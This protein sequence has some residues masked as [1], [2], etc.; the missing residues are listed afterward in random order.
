M[1]LALA[2]LATCGGCGKRAPSKGEAAAAGAAGLTEVDDGMSDGDAASLRATLLWS[3]AKDGELEDLATLAVHE[4][5]L[6]LMEAVR[7]PTLRRTAIEAMGYARGWAQLPFLVKVGSGKNDEEAKLALAAVVELAT[8][9]LRSEDPE[10]ASELRE[11]CVA[12]LALAR[13][14]AQSRPRRVMAV[15]ALRMMPCPSF[16]AGSDD[17]DGIPTDVDAE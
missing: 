6:G 15:R 5:A 9:P 2:T 3:N 14:T 8:R 1:V 16:D 17:E 11:G 12:L 13:N 4:G 10:D 7:E